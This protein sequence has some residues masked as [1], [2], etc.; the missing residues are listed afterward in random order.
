MATSRQKQAAQKFIKRWKQA[1]G[2]EEQEDRSF[3]IEL[4]QEVLEV[5]EPTK[6]I[7][8]QRKIRGRKADAFIE[9]KGILIEQKSRG[10][11]LDKKEKRGLT[12]HNFPRMV[13]PYE[14]GK[15]YADN[16]PHSISPRWIITSNF[17]E[18]RFYDLNDENP[19]ES[20]V[21]VSLDEL[22]DNLQL[23]D[24]FTSK[25]HSRLEKEKR[26]S[27]EAGEIVARLY[28]GFADQY[29]HLDTDPREHES[30]NILIVRLVFLLYAEDA[31][32][33]QSHLA[34]HD[35]LNSYHVQDC[36]SALI[37]LF[38]VLD[39][40]EEERD[41]YLSEQLSAFPYVN[42][43]LFAD[44]SII[45]PQF[46]T[47]LRFILLQEASR[48]FNWA[49]I[50][51]TIFGA[52]FE[53][54]LNPETRHERGMHYTSLE[55][56]HK[57]IDPLFLNALRAELQEIEAFKTEKVRYRRLLAFR[58]KLASIKVLDPACGSGNFL[59]ETYLSLRRL[60]NR[61]LENLAGFG[62]MGFE[63]TENLSPIHV[64]IN[65][66]HGI[67]I[68]DF[69][70]SVA[71]TALWIAESQMMEATQEIIK[72][73]LEFLPLTSIPSITCGN[74]LRLDWN[75]VIKAN[76]CSYVL[77]NPPFVGQD[78]KT[79][80]QTADMETVW[81]D[82]YN[83]YLDYVTAW[84]KKAADYYDSKATGGGG[85]FVFVSTNSITQGAPVAALFKPLFSRGW[86]ISFAW[87]TFKWTSEAR[88]Q[89][90]VHVVIIGM[91]R[92][93]R[94][95]VLFTDTD[96]ETTNN[97]NPYLIAAPTFFIT[98]RRIPLGPLAPAAIGSKPADGG[99]LQLK[100]ETDYKE[101]MADPI[102]SKYVRRCLGAKELIGNKKRWCLWLVDA[103]ESDLTASP[104]LI[105]RLS[106][107]RAFRLKSKKV[108]TRKL[109]SRPQLFGEIRPIPTKYVCIP[110]HF[111]GNRDY[112][113]ASYITDG[114]IATDACFVLDDPDGYAFSV[115]TSS[116]FMYWQNTV[117]GR[118]KSDCRFAST[119]VWNTFPL[120][121]TSNYQCLAVI[122][123]G[124]E[125]RK[126]RDSYTG[127]S[128]DQLYDRQ[129]FPLRTRLVQAHKQLD[130]AVLAVLGLRPDA[131]EDEVSRRLVELYSQ[132]A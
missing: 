104:I 125:V 48:Q 44:K 52:V 4:L 42:G 128:L 7:D 10:V 54:T 95:A 34:F 63:L 35:Y 87:T 94:D 49:D 59:T 83:G 36:R 110:R 78:G 129:T 86:R 84:Y 26:L 124:K 46:T 127:E 1:A 100:S 73:E 130:A 90:Q 112:F 117:G 89:A 107:V 103:P 17:D 118:L 80:T 88:S 40:P 126:A 37:R 62:Q 60:E 123:A 132:M 77:G 115:L 9:D 39:T 41:P 76:D 25:E 121:T 97:I 111:S 113:T 96:I 58:N 75:A 92:S 93:K 3:W 81:G 116:A 18:I 71:K 98:P 74:A 21:S 32:L 114:A 16:L 55:N 53:S 79:E 70:V 11:D 67:E 6:V 47:D 56:I 45:I 8:F 91:D 20:Y 23:F 38:E 14:Q 69:A 33:L 119:L 29:L 19:E 106:E 72:S 51:P 43:G 102:A 99:F 68:N 31:G 101:A 27:V 24:I 122:E 61:V 15:W 50:S 2:T 85:S 105:E 65:Q 57:V 13:T 66:M 108:T 30:L 131:S 5:P 120:P 22:A 109:S 28:D 12:E 64:S 82:D